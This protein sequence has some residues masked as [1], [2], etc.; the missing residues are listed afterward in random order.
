M[1]RVLEWPCMRRLSLIAVFL[2]MAATPT[3]VTVWLM[4]LAL[5]LP[6]DRDT[7]VLWPPPLAVAILGVLALLAGAVGG[8]LQWA[9]LRRDGLRARFIPATAVGHGVI[10]S[11][12]FAVPHWL[13]HNPHQ[14]SSALLA[15]S[16][17][18]ELLLMA[19][20]QLYLFRKLARRRA[21]IV[22]QGDPMRS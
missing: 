12:A 19:A 2:C 8:T 17:T 15:T 18:L 1:R 16:G 22:H 14:T 9:L 11:L 3:A 10:F 7:G 20:L 13:A 4:F 21:R 5:T 6:Y